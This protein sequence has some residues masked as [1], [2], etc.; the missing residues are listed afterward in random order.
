M[1]KDN[2]KMLWNILLVLA[3]TIIVVFIVLNDNIKEMLPVVLNIK[4]EYLILCLI[5]TFLWQF[6]IGISLTIFTRLIK[7]DYK[8]SSGFLNALVATLFNDITPSAT[9]GQI[10]QMFVFNKQG[11]KSGDALSILWTEFI[12]Y[13]ST[14]CLYGLFLIIVKIKF[15]L[16]EFS[17]LF[18]FVILGFILN[19]LVIVGLILLARY[20]KLQKW[21][22][23]KGIDIA[24]HFH[25]IKDKEATINNLNEQLNHFKKEANNL[26]YHKKEFIICV[27]LCVVRLTCYY[28]IP[29]IVFVALGTPISFKLFFDCLAIGSFVA[30]VSN[31]VPIPGASGGTE[32][33]FVSMFTHIFGLLNARTAVLIWR[34]FSYYLMML[35]GALAYVYY[36]FKEN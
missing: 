33:V 30:I 14:M 2:K 20:D 27:L 8:L 4:K 19:S 24:Y 25:L 18:I 6:L 35:V 23:S 26:K 11:I 12:M 15:F 32:L 16:N 13:Q 31:L 22:T 3:M 7:K 9:G 34:F 28:S 29:Y 36:K 17:H 21:I 10:A 1:L 5:I